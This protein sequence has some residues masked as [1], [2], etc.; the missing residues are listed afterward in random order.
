MNKTIDISLAGILFHLE[1]KA[2]YKLKK[3]LKSV[4]RSIHQTDDID[5]VMN[6]IE[7]RIA[8][9]LLQKQQHA[10]QVI[11][12]KHIDEVI[13]VLGQPEDF[14]EEI[15]PDAVHSSQNIKKS[16]FRDM[17]HSMIAGVAAGLAHYIGMDVTLMRLIFVV[18]LFVTHGSFILLYFLLWLIVPKARTASD[19][20]RMKGKSANLDNIVDQVATD[21]STKKKTNLGET[22]ETTGSEIGNI[23][24]KIIGFV[25]V[26][27]TGILIVG[28]LISALSFSPMSDMNLILNENLVSQNLHIPIGLISTLV[29]FVIAFPVVLLFLLGFKMLFPNTNPFQKNWLIIGFTLWILAIVYMSVK[30]I[31]IM[32]HKNERARV[33]TLE[34]QWQS[35]KDTL[36]L[37]VKAIKGLP[38]YTTSNSIKF[39]FYPAKD[40]LFHFKIKK[41]AEGVTYRDAKKNALE[42]EFDTQ[43]DTLNNTLIFS[44]MMRYPTGN[45]ISVRKVRVRI[46]VPENKIVKLSEP[47]SSL[48]YLYDCDFPKLLTNKNDD[49]ICLQQYDDISGASTYININEGD[50]QVK[51]SNTGIEINGKDEDGAAHIKI[52]NHGIKIKAKDHG[53]NTSVNIDN[54][55]V[56]INNNPDN[57]RDT[58]KNDK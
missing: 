3:Y 26:L 11:N 43:Q 6:E 28:L 22:I 29:F 23:L 14:E 30:S 38:N 33:V 18:L 10:Q 47:V 27:A 8:E 56:R 2:Y 9:L 54:D 35:G 20:L 48:S 39:D 51:I 21:D 45:L 46:E 55:G 31:S 40:S 13:A 19:K 4:R 50:A 36:F 32:S 7:A 34:R 12:E 16:L 53:K 52:D 1:E 57:S 44:S 25:L 5:E 24:V 15:Q 49:I 37:D 17:D 41:I 58:N 42:I